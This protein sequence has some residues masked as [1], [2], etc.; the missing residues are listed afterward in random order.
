MNE[1]SYKLAERLVPTTYLHQASESR[2]ARE[3]LI[4][5]LMEQH[6]CPE[7]G[8]DDATIEL[9]LNDLALMDS[10]NFPHNCGVGER[11]ARIYSGLVS[12]RHYRLGHGIGRSGD[13]AEVQPK[14]AGS[15]LLNK[16]T[17]C[18]VLDVIRAT[19][20]RKTAAC[21]VVPLATGMSMVLCLLTVRQQR[22]GA[23]YV[24]WPRIDQKSCFKAIITAG[25][26][27]VV[28]ENCLDG[29]ELRTDVAEIDRQ[30]TSL[31]P[32]SIAAV[33]T[34]TSCF[35]PRGIDKLE[36]VARLCSRYGVPHI[37]NNAYGVQSTKCMH[38]IQEAARVGRVDAF[39]Q[40]TDKNFMVPVG[41]AVIAGFDS[42]FIQQVGK[43][44]PGRA[45]GSPVVDLFITLLSMGIRGHKKLLED[46]K[47]LKSLLTQRMEG[48]AEKY[49]LRVLNTKNNPISIAMTLPENMNIPLTEL[50]SRLFL[51]G[52]SGTRVIRTSDD[53]MIAGSRFIG[54]GSHSKSYPYAYLTAAASIGMTEED[55]DLFIQRLDKC[56]EK[57]T[58][59]KNTKETYGSENDVTRRDSKSYT[60]G[61]KGEING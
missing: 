41:G 34:T 28:I 10:N 23:K 47:A 57:F 42:A 40:S 19:G 56:L 53:K 5:I 59:T 54:W 55:V 3:K 38:H 27:P 60:R 50:G 16:L 7:E 29:D 26:E 6:K 15:S 33:M 44:Y 30:I 14:A 51:R 43:M 31:K 46:R 22:P 61:S 20:A 8:W 45:S 1:T 12:K 32:E 58:G 36:D 49:G 13:I 11:E 17:N 4:R 9:F 21:L 25:F 52:V 18:M 37:I 24:I 35:A 2:T 48:V 39:V